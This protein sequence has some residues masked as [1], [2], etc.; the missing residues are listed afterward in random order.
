MGD[1]G[2]G[3]AALHAEQMMHRDIRD[4]VVA[5][6]TELVFSHEFHSIHRSF[7]P[8]PPKHTDF[9]AHFHANTRIPEA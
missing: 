2:T 6:E 1:V 7:A 8:L 9:S 5:I 4:I 3:L